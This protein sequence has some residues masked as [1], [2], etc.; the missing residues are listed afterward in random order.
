MSL[1]IFLGPRFRA[2]VRDYPKPVRAEIGQ[3]INNI[4]SSLGH[5]HLHAGLA[6]R[7]LAK[8]C[9]ELRVGL[10]LRLVFKSDADSI[11]FVFAGT[12]DEVQRFLKSL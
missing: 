9:F 12:H 2:I 6:I 1:S 11:L 4:Q 7:K 8:N 3:A 10:H 5:P